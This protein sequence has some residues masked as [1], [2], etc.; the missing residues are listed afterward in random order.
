M[1]PAPFQRQIE[2]SRLRLIYSLV[3]QTILRHRLP[4]TE[5]KTEDQIMNKQQPKIILGTCTNLFIKNTLY[6]RIVTTSIT[7]KDTNNKNKLHDGF[8]GYN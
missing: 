1:L 2:C 8:S 5:A 4:E 6:V 7:M 3:R